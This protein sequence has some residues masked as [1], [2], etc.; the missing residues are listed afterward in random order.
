LVDWLKFIA[1]DGILSGIG[2]S[3][4]QF[5]VLPLRNFSKE[6]LPKATM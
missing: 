3:G 4:L 5:P 2:I 6:Q 1:K